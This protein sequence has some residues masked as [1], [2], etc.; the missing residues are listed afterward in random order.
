MLGKLVYSI[1]LLACAV[2]YT[3]PIPFPHV[4]IYLLSCEIDKCLYPD[5]TVNCLI[6][7]PFDTL[8]SIHNPSSLTAYSDLP[9]GMAVQ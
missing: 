1:N 6:L 7:L 8:Y 3:V 5:S 2:S 9:V 4:N